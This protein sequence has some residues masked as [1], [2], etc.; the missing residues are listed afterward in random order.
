[1]HTASNQEHETD[2]ALAEKR[3]LIEAFE[4]AEADLTARFAALLDA[5]DR[6]DAARI[7]VGV[8]RARNG[9]LPLGSYPQ[10]D[11]IARLTFSVRSAL[12]FV[13]SGRPEAW[14]RAKLALGAFLP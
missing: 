7:A 13:A 3:A 9:H 12:L 5:F 11:E 14:R 1:M 4:K 2:A 10:T 8:H 6:H